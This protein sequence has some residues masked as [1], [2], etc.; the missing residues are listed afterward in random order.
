MEF[1]LLVLDD[2]YYKVELAGGYCDGNCSVCRKCTNNRNIVT[3]I[4]E[5][6]A[7]FYQKYVL[8]HQTR[9]AELCKKVSKALSLDESEKRILIQSALLHD[10]GKLLINFKILSK[11]TSLS[12]F[13]R[14]IMEFHPS[15]GAEWLK[16]RDFP[17][18]IVT[19]V[20]THHERYDGIGYPYGL[21]GDEIPFLARVLAVCDAFEVMIKGRHYKL[22]KSLT[23]A[24]NELK[25]E[26]NIQFDGEIVIAFTEMWYNEIKRKKKVVV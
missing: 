11:D 24:L 13:E 8:D 10:I 2:G 12:P 17:E 22:P 19:I 14:R 5:E 7:E 16:E 6:N 25:K 26:K 1:A 15:K 23:E 21:K 20:E 4:R 18:E 9:T 3:L